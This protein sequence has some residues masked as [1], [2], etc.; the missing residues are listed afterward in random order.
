[1]RICVGDNHNVSYRTSHT[2]RSTALSLGKGA[3]FA[4]RDPWIRELHTALPLDH[5]LSKHVQG[6]IISQ[7]NILADMPDLCFNSSNEFTDCTHLFKLLVLDKSFHLQQQGGS[8]KLVKLSTNK[9][10]PNESSFEARHFVWNGILCSQGHLTQP[11]S[12]F[13]ARQDAVT[14]FSYSGSDLWPPLDS[15][16][17]QLL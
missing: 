3:W 13:P 11:R 12:Y 4:M 9:Q 17:E 1:M 8:S 10:I 15:Q 5:R 16:S 6:N 7:I 2:S 14:Y